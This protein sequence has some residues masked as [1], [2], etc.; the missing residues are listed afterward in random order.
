MLTDG[1]NPF[2]REISLIGEGDFEKLKNAKVAVIGLGGVGSYVVEALARAGVG[3]L[4]LCDNDV[5]APHN[6]NRQLFALHSTIGKFKAEVAALRV[7]DINPTAKVIVKK[8]RYDAQSA[9]SFDFSSYDYVVD[10]IDLVTHKLLLIQAAKQCG[11][12]VISCMGTGNKLNA[13]FKVADIFESKICPLSVVMRKEAR[14]RNL[15]NFKVVYSEE[16]AKKPLFKDENEV[17]RQTA[18]SISFVPSTAG[19]LIAGEVIKDIINGKGE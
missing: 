4:L 17:R 12:P 16:V 7:I 1:N 15:G 19:L 8:E 2:I 13:S 9:P 6:I 11:V 14:R 10:C 5:I 3:H 18:A